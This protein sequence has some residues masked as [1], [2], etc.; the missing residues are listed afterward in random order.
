M[1]KAWRGSTGRWIKD[2]RRALKDV[3]AL[4][5]IAAG[6]YLTGVLSPPTGGFCSAFQLGG[7]RCK[8]GGRRGS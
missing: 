4:Q 5:V 2:V 8:E 6:L 7:E 3:A 1:G